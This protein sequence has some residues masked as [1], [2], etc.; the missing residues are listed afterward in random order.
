MSPPQ[1]LALSVPTLVA[2]VARTALSSVC[3]P[4]VCQVPVQS[5]VVQPLS[6]QSQL[7]S[8][9][10]LKRSKTTPWSFLKKLATELQYAGEWSRS[11]ILRPWPV[12]PSAGGGTRGVQWGGAVAY[13]APA[14]RGAG[15]A[16]D[17][18]REVA[19]PSGGG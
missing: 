16:G 11:A 5:L 19:A 8:C 1:P 17:A 9:G 6:Q 4:A 18:V 15:E 3:M 12:L 14:G 10:S 2:P 7:M 13:M